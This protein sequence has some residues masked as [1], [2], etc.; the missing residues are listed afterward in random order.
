MSRKERISQVI[1][2]FAV[3]GSAW[4]GWQW[5]G[6][7]LPNPDP[8]NIGGKSLGIDPKQ[9][10]TEDQE[11]LPLTIDGY[12]LA[13]NVDETVYQK[14]FE[15]NPGEA[16]IT[17]GHQSAYDHFSKGVALLQ[18]TATSEDRPQLDQE[19]KIL[20]LKSHEFDLSD[21]FQFHLAAAIVD[22]ELRQF[23]PPEDITD[24][25]KEKNLQQLSLLYWLKE[26][27]I[28][29]KFESDAY[30]FFS[31]ELMVT[32]ASSLYH[33]RE[34]VSQPSLIQFYRTG[35]PRYPNPQKASGLYGCGRFRSI[36][37]FFLKAIK[38]DVDQGQ[39]CPILASNIL[40]PINLAHEV[41]HYIGYNSKPVSQDDF[42]EV[43]KTAKEKFDNQVTNP[44]DLFLSLHAADNNMENYAE[45]FAQYLT[46]GSE[47]RQLLRQMRWWD[48]GSYQ[49]LKA[50][51]QFFKEGLNGTEFLVNGIT[52][53]DSDLA[54]EETG[55][56][57]GKRFIIE[58]KSPSPYLERGIHLRLNPGNLASTNKLLVVYNNEIVEV[59]GGPF[60]LIGQTQDSTYIFWKV[61]ATT[62]QGAKITGWLAREWLGEELPK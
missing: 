52:A 19:G 39:D 8:V 40:N 15:N 10:S 18:L 50:E 20:V 32:L 38:G 61:T 2:L 46:N 49:I 13:K 53:S 21:N 44:E 4:A 62:Q 22:I 55:N 36:P 58:D 29:I 57:I 27:N 31:K 59:I 30:A 6:Y 33:T 37:E 7:Q 51:Y 26:Q 11:L 41:G 56:L 48:W 45:T 23:L 34:V 35:D 47:L 16:I 5:R 54:K 14:M 1:T 3:A 42:E 17:L 43:V 60:K 9:I 12:F 28:N 24:W 25:D